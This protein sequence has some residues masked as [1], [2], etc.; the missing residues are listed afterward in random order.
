MEGENMLRNWK[1]TLGGVGMIL[2]GIGGL[3]MTL[4]GQGE[5]PYEVSVGLV[6]GGAALLLAR[7]A[8]TGSD[9]V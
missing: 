8:G 1:T 9:A 7:D 6:T 3:A 4:T 2:M 5:T